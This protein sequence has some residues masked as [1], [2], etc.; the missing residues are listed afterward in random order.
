MR[1]GARRDAA[2]DPAAID[3]EDARAF[4]GEF[5]GRGNP[6]DTRANDCDIAFGVA[7]K[8]CCVRGDRTLHPKRFAAPVDQ[9]VHRETRLIDDPDGSNGGSGDWFLRAPRHQA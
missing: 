2:R 8:R 3:H 5:V 7:L 6:G 4:L 1:G 9:I